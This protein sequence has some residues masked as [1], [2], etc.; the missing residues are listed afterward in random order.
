MNYYVNGILDRN[1]AATDSLARKYASDNHVSYAEGLKAVVHK[2]SQQQRK[3]AAENPGVG[4]AIQ[5]LGATVAN[6]PKQSDGSVDISLA[7]EVINN[8]EALRELA[9]QAAGEHLNNL[10]QRLLG[11]AHPHENVTLEDC[12]RIVAR[13]NPAI[14]SM[15]GGNKATEAGLKGILWTIFRYDSERT[16]VRTYSTDNNVYFDSAG[17]EIHSYSFDVVRR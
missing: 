16:T 8:S 17:H 13:D 7:L 2:Q 15:Y 6:L 3:Y 5:R 10:S 14:A 11:S 1:G 9:K 4:M 12:L